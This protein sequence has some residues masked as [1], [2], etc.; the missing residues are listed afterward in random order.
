MHISHFSKQYSKRW[1]SIE[2][3]FLHWYRSEKDSNSSGCVDLRYVRSINKTTDQLTHSLKNPQFTFAIVCE[4]RDLFLRASSQV[5]M[6]N[7]IRALHYNAD[8][9]RGGSGSAISGDF[10]DEPRSN[11]RVRGE[12]RIVVTCDATLFLTTPNLCCHVSSLILS[13]SLFS[14]ASW[15]LRSSL[16]R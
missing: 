14:V 7:W 15:S 10:N 6:N 2:G 13:L 8:K 11:F 5:D 3:K 16:A 1:F 12:M 9:S 4:E